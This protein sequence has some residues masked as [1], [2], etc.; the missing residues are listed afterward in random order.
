MDNALLTY[1]LVALAF[2]VTPGPD[3]IL[4]IKHS[5]ASGTAF[6]VTVAMGAASGSLVWGVA[7]AVGLASALQQAPAALYAIKIAGALYLAVLGIQSI[8][9]AGKLHA[10]A[11]SGRREAGSRWTGFKAG[12]VADLLNP[13]MGAFYLA[14]LPQF[15]PAGGNVL[16]W[17][18][19]F[20]SIELAIAIVCL[21]SY[22]LVADVAR[23]L[24][25]SRRA[26]AWLD[27]FLGTVLV[28][29]AVRVAVD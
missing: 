27:R 25:T 24:L 5:L 11:T 8:R 19:L 16:Q 3:A 13:K 28:A 29:V 23:H 22:A 14:L 4:A 1:T 26:V 9:H 20:M 2:G 17:S 21:S 10:E 7:A 6:G 12:F 15:I 18:L